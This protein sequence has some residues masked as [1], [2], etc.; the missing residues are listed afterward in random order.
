MTRRPARAGAAML[1][2]TALALLTIP[3][4][5]GVAQPA[6]AVDDEAPSP[7]AE[8]PDGPVSMVITELDAVLGPGAVP[9][10]DES[11]ST[12]EEA[13]QLRLRM[14]VEHTGEE[15]IGDLTVVVETYPAETTRSGLRS[16]LAGDA[17]LDSVA[18]T[19]VHEQPVRA[20]GPL[21]PGDL[22]GV[23][24]TIDA[25]EIAW[26]E[27]GGV[28]PMR[29]AITRGA[30]VL[31]EVTTAAVWLDSRP[32]E[33]LRTAAVW[34]VD[35][36]PWR[37][38][39][40]TYPRGTDTSLRSG[41]GL[42]AQL[43]AVERHPGS[44]VVLAPPAHL[45]EDLRDRAGGF[46][47]T[48]RTDDGALER[49][50]VSG[51]DPAAQRSN[52][53]LGR[54]RVA[55]DGSSSGPLARPYADADLGAL[56][57]DDSARALAGELARAGRDRLEA[58]GQRIP[59]QR[60]FLLPAGAGPAALDL[61]PADTVIVPYGAVEGPD[62]DAD[63]TLPSPVRDTTSAGGRP[64]TLLIADPYLT[65]L[66]GATS[67]RSPATTAHRILVE[68][69]MVHFEAPGTSGRALTILPPE[70]WD[71]STD[72]AQR[73]LGD[74][75]A[76]PWLALED[77]RSVAMAAP[78]GPATS[79]VEPGEATL[80]SSERTRIVSLLADLEAVWQARVGSLATTDPD[81][82]A[83]DDGHIDDRDPTD[84]RDE[85]LRA[86]SRWYPSGSSTREGLVTDVA[87]AIDQTVG[88][89]S[90]A[91][92]TTVTL[93]AETGTI[94]VTLQHDEGGPIDVVVEVASQAR[95]TW[96]EGASTEVI[97]LQPGSTQTVSF[98]TRALS[99]GDFS[100]TVRVTDPTGRLEF[101]RTSLS[102]R[103]TAVSGPALSII[104]GLVVVLL[105]V[106]LVRRRP[107]RP[108]ELVR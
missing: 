57:G 29:V 35:V 12:A 33:P 48:E 90:L 8:P 50:R 14:L 107:S 100:V 81:L 19:H 37:Q 39:A 20:D 46:V 28:H 45:L 93:T 7:P 56:A 101:D 76:A 82:E 94:P 32:E 49:R 23:E 106:G 71:P 34:P 44:E 77:A 4:G 64:V 65:E 60:S 54:L 43:R 84:L 87:G 36:P 13:Q 11:P 96:P 80:D 104:G 3:A 75:G 38:A 27:G 105:L 83:E 21:E 72:L 53:V 59:E 42:D 86:T 62:L 68:T 108:L 10:A 103:S 2:A 16:T 98:D 88:E 91:S 40:G 5:P 31:D 61:V 95:L 92:G 99:T 51:D 17:P 52:E 6:P 73:I 69:A 41:S 85:L 89:V 30:T 18:A 22:A 79:L 55:L 24:I 70:D 66:L 63:P 97:R 15:P 26:A 67:G 25:E 47:R 78:R 9:P 1:L 102:V 58:F 74:L